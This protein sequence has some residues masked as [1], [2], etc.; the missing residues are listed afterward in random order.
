M[1]GAQ[2]QDMSQVVEQFNEYGY[3]VVEDLI[4]RELA[5][6]L[7]ERLKDHMTS[8][9]SDG[10]ASLYERALF[11]QLSQ[12]DLDLFVNLISHPFLL[13]L[14]KGT[15]GEGF[16][17]AEV[18][19]RWMLPGEDGLGLHVGSPAHELKNHGFAFPSNCFVL[20][21]SWCLDDMTSENGNRFFMPFSHH[22]GRPPREGADYPDI[23]EITAPAGSLIAFNSATWHGYHP[24]ESQDK[25]RLEFCSAF[26]VPWLDPDV[27]GW[28][29]MN[30]SV[31]DKMPEEIQRACRKVR[32]G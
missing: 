5:E 6:K 13:D 22:S 4:P 29:L 3:L 24:N 16:Q 15:L 19:S 25:S 12:D 2:N 14:A 20:T 9:G 31:R 23:A 18:G 10:K 7:A 21:F 32:E 17:L 11:N 1:T 27:I 30:K 26:H 8:N 28:Q